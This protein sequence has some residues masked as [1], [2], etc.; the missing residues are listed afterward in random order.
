MDVVPFY[1]FPHTDEV[2]EF[3]LRPREIARARNEA[4]RSCRKQH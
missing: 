3:S 2:V 1:N 4:Q